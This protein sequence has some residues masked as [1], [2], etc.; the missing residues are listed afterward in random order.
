MNYIRRGERCPTA[1]AMA[2]DSHGGNL[3]QHSEKR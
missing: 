1:E 2:D 3:E